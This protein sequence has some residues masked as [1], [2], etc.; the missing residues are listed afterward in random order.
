M[1][2]S[3]PI[4][5]HR[6]KKI[7]IGIVVAPIALFIVLLAYGFV[8]SIFQQSKQINSGNYSSSPAAQTPAPTHV[9]SGAEQ[10]LIEGI[11]T[12]SYGASNPKLTIVEF[13][14]F[15]CPYCLAS[16]P[17]LRELAATYKDS[18]KIIF[19]DWPGHQYSISLA[20]GAYCAGEQG[21]FWEMHDALYRNQS[22][23]FG[24][25]KNDIAGL[26]AGLGVY[27]QQFQN[28]FD[29][30]KYLSLIQKNT[31]DSQ[32]LGVKGTPT[33]FF[34]GIKIEGA[35]TKAELEQLIKSYVK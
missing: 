27:N 10:S 20:L 24:A 9:Y 35:Q 17:G 3:E 22:E 29:T 30:K 16:A 12:Q 18:V 31:A 7:I 15:A 5:H 28:C 25:D 19:R 6:I 2:P 33:W 34:N 4:R 13:A 11:G 8:S 14:D 26:A 23:T 1:L 32:T 21:K